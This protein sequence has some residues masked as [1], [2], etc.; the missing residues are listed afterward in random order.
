MSMRE[1]VAMK[2]LI[3][4]VVGMSMLAMVMS[5][6]GTILGAGAGAGAG[7]AVSA[8]TGN[9]VG[10]GALIGAGVGGAA[11]AIYDITKKK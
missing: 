2:T 4:S 7:A 8:A 6:C 11:G 5:G 9:D 10:K 3:S 1:D